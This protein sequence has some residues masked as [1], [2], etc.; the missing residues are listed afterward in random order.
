MTCQPCEVGNA[1]RQA[2]DDHRAPGCEVVD[3]ARPAP[4]CTDSPLDYRWR[5]PPG[6]SGARRLNVGDHPD[7]LVGM[8]AIE[9]QGDELADRMDIRTQHVGQPP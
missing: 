1:R 9:R 6:T 8:L 5:I 3:G 4:R 2:R 7:I